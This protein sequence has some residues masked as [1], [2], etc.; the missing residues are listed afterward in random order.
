MFD[1]CSVGM[2]SRQVYVSLCECVVSG[3]G[4]LREKG[5]LGSGYVLARV[6]RA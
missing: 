3:K 2:G 5:K 6:F 1:V 4:V